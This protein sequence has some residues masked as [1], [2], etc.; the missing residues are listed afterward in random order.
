M[1]KHSKHVDSGWYLWWFKFRSM[2]MSPTGMVDS[3][4]TDICPTSSVWNRSLYG[5]GAHHG[6][7]PSLG[8]PSRT[9]GVLPGPSQGRDQWISGLEKQNGRGQGDSGAKCSSALW[10]WWNYTLKTWM[11]W[12]STIMNKNGFKHHTWNFDEWLMNGRVCP[13][14]VHKTCR[15][16]LYD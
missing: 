13:K 5:S 14:M 9:K 8:P 3:Q 15:I 7:K 2:H 16:W 11:F 6:C 1:N 12:S 4:S 10:K